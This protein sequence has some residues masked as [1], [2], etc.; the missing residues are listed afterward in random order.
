MRIFS[1]TILLAMLVSLSVRGQ[2]TLQLQ[3]T[4]RAEAMSNAY[5]SFKKGDKFKIHAAVG[6]SEYQFTG[7]GY[8]A[9][10]DAGKSYFVEGV[11]MKMLSLFP[12]K[13]VIDVWHKHMLL[14]N[15]ISE[16]FVRGFQYDL[17][18]DLHLEAID[19]I[20]SLS[21]QDR[22]FNDAYLED[23][24]YSLVSKIHGGVSHYNR[25]GNLSVR[26]LK[27]TE[28]N[29]FILPNGAM[30]VTTG[31]LSTIKSEDELAGILAHEIAHFV[32]DHHV[33]NHNKEIDRKK[34]AEFWAAFA[35]VAA[36]GADFYLA[37]K[38][39]NHIPGV[40]TASTMIAAAVLSEAITTRLGIKY[41]HD[42]ESK[43]DLAASEIIASLSYSEYGLAVALHRLKSYFVKT[44]DF[45]AL[46]G[47]GSHP[48]IDVRINTM[49]NAFEL[50]SFS[51]LQYLRAVSLV[52]S[53]NAWV[54]FWVNNQNAAAFD[55]V[56]RNL[57][58]GVATETD[59]IIAAII[60]RRQSAANEVLQ[61][62][63]KLLQQ[64]KALNVTP[65][66]QIAKEEGLT[67]L[68]LN[69]P[70]D[71]KKSFEIY[72]KQLN[73]FKAGNE[74]KM[75]A[76]QISVIEE[77]MVWTQRMIFKADKL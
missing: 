44:G 18:N 17:R 23:Y 54:E 13:N 48:A 45:L 7:P 52:N 56:N 57:A 61:E 59:Y 51:N 58:S 29:A 28:P 53:Y 20:N 41:S 68:R 16:L 67:F 76:S 66:I 70:E 77:E 22:F 72:L 21:Q 31:L 10:D 55:L 36:A 5:G 47:G 27:S 40:L 1:F 2:A 50:D 9:V 11:N 6:R 63:L 34:R 26:I 71:A 46:S 64:A 14:N 75:A 74:V 3:S 42:Q 8:L 15:S 33:I 19:Y 24:L 65:H 39:E 69:R 4:I 60:K 62:A 49:G 38:N 73:D 25:P 12:E 37:S 32:L 43:A 35:T 30:L